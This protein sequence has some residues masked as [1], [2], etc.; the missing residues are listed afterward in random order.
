MQ[1]TNVHDTTKALLNLFL[2]LTKITNKS[3]TWDIN[4]E[5]VKAKETLKGSDEMRN[6]TEFSF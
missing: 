5:K 2:H 1:T 4:T 6:R 3:F